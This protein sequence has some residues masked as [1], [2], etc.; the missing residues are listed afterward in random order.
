MY[1]KETAIIDRLN[2]FTGSKIIK[3]DKY[4]HVY[5]KI[6]VKNKSKNIFGSDDYKY[7]KN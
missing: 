7:K 6:T 2:V 5:Y 1:N 3:V 4:F